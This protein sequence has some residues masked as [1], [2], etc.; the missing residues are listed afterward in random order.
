MRNPLTVQVTNWLP[1]RRDVE[2]C[3]ADFKR[4]K[5]NFGVSYRNGAWAVWRE[6][7]GDE[8][9]EIVSDNPP[10]AWNEIY[11]RGILQPKNDKK[12]A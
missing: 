1:S 8:P 12:V 7:K 5:M 4:R 2:F 10:T 9:A 6:A 11:V 3:I